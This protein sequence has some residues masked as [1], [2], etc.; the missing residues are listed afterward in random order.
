MILSS[1]MDIHTLNLLIG[2]IE[3]NRDLSLNQTGAGSKAFVWHWWRVFETLPCHFNFFRKSVNQIWLNRCEAQSNHDL[4]PTTGGQKWPFPVVN[5]CFLPGPKVASS[6]SQH[7]FSTPV[8]K[9]LI[10]EFLLLF[11]FRE[12]FKNT[13]CGLWSRENRLVD[14]FPKYFTSFDRREKWW[15]R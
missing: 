8:V 11:R 14:R 5:T 3:V 2:F 10:Y 9:G 7:S 4:Q 12:N 15:I 1:Y 6:R 13:D